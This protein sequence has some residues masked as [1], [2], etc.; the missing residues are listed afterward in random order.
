MLSGVL[1]YFEAPP[2]PVWRLASVAGMLCLV[3]AYL[4]NQRGATRPDSTRYLSANALGAGVLA[5]YSAVIGEWV[6]FGLEGFWCLASL[7]ALGRRGRIAP[8]PGAPP[9]PPA[10]ESTQSP[11][12]VPER[13]SP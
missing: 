11:G 9:A 6:F 10:S 2:G 5:A 7:Q 8:A 3:I 13:R 12:P 4:V 1:H